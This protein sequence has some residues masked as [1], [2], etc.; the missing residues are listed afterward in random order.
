ML[1]KCDAFLSAE[2]ASLWTRLATFLALLYARCVPNYLATIGESLAHALLAGTGQTPWSRLR[3][4]SSDLHALPIA[5]AQH[6][7]RVALQTRATTAPAPVRAT[8]PTLALRNA[9][10]LAV[11]ALL[12]RHADTAKTSASIGSA[13]LAVAQFLANQR[14]PATFLTTFHANRVP[15]HST[16]M[17]VL[18]ANGLLALASTTTRYL[19]VGV[20]PVGG[21]YALSSLGAALA[22]AALSAAS[23]API[24]PTLPASAHRDATLRRH[25]HL[26]L[27]PR[28]RL[29]HPTVRA[30]VAARHGTYALAIWRLDADA[31]EAVWVLLARKADIGRRALL[32]HAEPAVVARLARAASASTSVRPALLAVAVGEASIA[33]H[34]ALGAPGHA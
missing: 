13:V 29:T 34:P 3:L 5:V 7:H 16:A 21:R 11:Y 23:T 6:G 12:P 31:P 10:T 14:T 19:V 22:S 25:A 18:A 24:G 8:L 2:S 26:C 1:R 33:R 32:A 4:A 20:A 28:S 15:R 17:R 9:D 27:V 30:D